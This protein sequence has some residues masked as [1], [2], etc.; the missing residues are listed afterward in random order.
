[1]KL[2]LCTCIEQATTP[3]TSKKKSKFSSKLTFRAKQILI[4]NETDQAD[5]N[6]L[7]CKLN[8]T[9]HINS[10]TVSFIVSRKAKQTKQGSEL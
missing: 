4:N 2:C 9:S 3:V 8:L 6:L 10:I 5:G 1:M 7:A